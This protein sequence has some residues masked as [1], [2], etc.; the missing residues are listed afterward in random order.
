MADNGANI[1]GGADNSG[2]SKKQDS[3]IKV[4]IRCR[5]PLDFE[6]K[7]GHTFEKLHIESGQKAIR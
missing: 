1:F 7:A 3:N 6:H 2:N 5:P 4:A